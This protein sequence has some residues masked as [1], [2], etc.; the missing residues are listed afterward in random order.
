VDRAVTYLN[1]NQQYM[2][3]GKALANGWPITTGMIEGAC[4]LV[5]EDRFGIT[6]AR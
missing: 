3:Y 1:N 2:K 4:R 5:I 6:G